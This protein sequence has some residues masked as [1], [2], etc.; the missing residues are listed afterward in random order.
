M[1]RSAFG[2]GSIYETLDFEDRREQPEYE[3]YNSALSHDDP[4]RYSTADSRLDTSSIQSRAAYST[5]YSRHPA[6]NSVYRHFET[7]LPNLNEEEPNDDVPDSLLVEENPQLNEHQ[8]YY[9]D[10]RPSDRELDNMERGMSPRRRQ[11]PNRTPPLNVWR[12]VD[13]KERALWRWA[14]TENLDIFLSRVLYFYFVADYQ[15]IRLL[16]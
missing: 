7:T 10:N 5:R 2:K 3:L 1:F 14:N 12:S 9:D 6:T 8:E 16:L 11:E 13:P 15:G 4:G